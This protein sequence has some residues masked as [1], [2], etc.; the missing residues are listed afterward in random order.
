MLQDQQ[1]NAIIDWLDI[2]ANAQRRGFAAARAFLILA[3]YR[4]IAV[5]HGGAL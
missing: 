1:G 2:R 5:N 4:C 3:R